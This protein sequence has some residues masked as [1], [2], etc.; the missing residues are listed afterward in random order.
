MLVCYWHL[1]P[2][3]GLVSTLSIFGLIFPPQSTPQQQ[4]KSNQSKTNQNPFKVSAIQQDT[5]VTLSPNMVE[6][7][8]LKNKPRPCVIKQCDA[9]TR[10]SEK[11]LQLILW[12]LLIRDKMFIISYS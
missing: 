6:D 4:I 10:T 1:I 9:R 2:I 8:V 5:C 3:P 12:T 11:Q 7:M